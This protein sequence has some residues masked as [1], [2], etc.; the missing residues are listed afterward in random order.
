MQCEQ[1]LFATRSLLDE[2]LDPR[3]PR[4]VGERTVATGLGLLHACPVVGSGSLRRDD[5]ARSARCGSGRAN[6]CATQRGERYVVGGNLAALR[7]VNVAI[8]RGYL[9]Q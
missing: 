8:W 4:V 1:F 5:A 9:P 7:R 2:V 6:V 3:E